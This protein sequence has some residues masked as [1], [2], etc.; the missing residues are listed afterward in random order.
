MRYDCADDDAKPWEA[1]A[2]LRKK[3]GID[4]PVALAHEEER[5]SKV[6]AVTMYCDGTFDT[7]VPGSFAALRKIHAFRFG[8]IYD[9]AGE[10]RTVNLAKGGF[11]FASALYLESAV[12]AVERMPQSTFDQIV[13]KYV[14]MNVAHPFRE[15]NGRSG[16]IWL[17]HMLRKELRKTVDWPHRT[18]T[19]CYPPV[20]CNSDYAPVYFFKYL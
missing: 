14:E 9:F 8:K 2:M 12:K 3:L 16:H 20:P 4:D 1:L 5:I 7:L 13:E 6:A 17:D 15:G 18:G 19:P 10:V 11:R